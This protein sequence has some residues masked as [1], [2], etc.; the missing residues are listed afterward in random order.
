MAHGNFM[1]EVIKSTDKTELFEYSAPTYPQTGEWIKGE[2]KGAGLL[3]VA[4]NHILRTGVDG[5]GAYTR[6]QCVQVVVA[7]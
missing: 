5:N 2:G 6:L 7:K 1:I 4:V 3:V